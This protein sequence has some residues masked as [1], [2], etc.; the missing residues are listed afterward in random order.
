MVPKNILLRPRAREGRFHITTP[1]EVSPGNA[2]QPS[3]GGRSKPNNT[4][5][6]CS[7]RGEGQPMMT[8]LA[9]APYAA[10]SMFCT[11]CRD[12]GFCS[13]RSAG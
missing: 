1:S 4:K 11:E 2:M 13:A 7:K 3:G 12:Q 8:R 10:G 9:E 5:V 6:R